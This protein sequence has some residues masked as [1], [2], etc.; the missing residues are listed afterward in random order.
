MEFRIETR[1]GGYLVSIGMDN[2]SDWLST[3]IKGHRS[4]IVSDKN[5]A[6]LYSNEVSK[7]LSG[8]GVTPHWFTISP[9]EGSKSLDTVKELF[10]WALEKRINRFL[11]CLFLKQSVFICV[12]PR[13]NYRIRN[14]GTVEP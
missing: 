9:G 3:N 10:K 8:N 2:I 14:R 13:L 7:I 11:H 12:N 4:F 5:V 1:W 6:S